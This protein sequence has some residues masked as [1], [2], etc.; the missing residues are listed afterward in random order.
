MDLTLE[1]IQVMFLRADGG[2]AGAR[3]AF[4]QLEPSCPALR[5]RKF[6]STYQ[7]VEYRAC[8]ALLPRDDARQLGLQTWVIP[9]G[10]Y[11]REKMT[12]WASRLP[13]TGNT[14]MAMA[15]REKSRVDTTRPSIEFYRSQREVILFLPVTR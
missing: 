15:D 2:P 1:D 3:A 5:G 6:Y 8:V 14:F 11:V 9:G 10:L 4:E 13:E 7:G 12:D